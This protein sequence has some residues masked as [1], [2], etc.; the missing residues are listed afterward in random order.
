MAQSHDRDHGPNLMVPSSI[1]KYLPSMVRTELSK[2]PPSDQDAFIEE[3]K[4]KSK[5]MLGTYLCSLLYCHYAFLGRWGMT[6][7]M[8]LVG[9]ITFGIVSFFWWIVDLF[10]I[11]GLVSNYN[12]DVAV[13]VLRNFKAIHG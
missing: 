11:P 13:D 8:W 5:G 1:D 2:L 6:I 4:R 10:R 3:F 9:I 12:R 7:I